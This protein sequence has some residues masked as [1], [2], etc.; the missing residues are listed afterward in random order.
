MAKRLW[1]NVIDRAIEAY[2]SGE[3]VYLYGAKNVLLT[4]EAQIRQ[5]FKQEPVYFSRYSEEE[6]NQIVRNS[7]GKIADDCSDWTD[8]K[9]I[10]HYS[11]SS[12]IWASS[13][14]RKAS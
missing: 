12:N 7:L 1:S 2:K 14:C 9:T 5:Y 6:K 13:L 8:N 3:Y 4:S 10:T 11:Y